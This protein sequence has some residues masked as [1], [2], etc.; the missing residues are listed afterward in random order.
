MLDRT[1]REKRHSKRRLLVNKHI[2][3]KKPLEN[4]RIISLFVCVHVISIETKGTYHKFKALWN[5][6]K[7]KRFVNVILVCFLNEIF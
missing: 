7:A 6:I 5:S 3:K 1:K 2:I 4:V